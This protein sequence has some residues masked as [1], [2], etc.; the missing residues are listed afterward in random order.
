MKRTIFATGAGLAVVGMLT[1][2]A[3][4]AEASELAEDQRPADATTEVVER[5]ELSDRRVDG[6]RFGCRA[7]ATDTGVVVGCRWRPTRAEDAVSYQVWRIL[8]RGER[9]LVHRGGLDVTSFVDEELGHASF[10]RYAVL[11]LN[12]NKEIVGRSRV[13]EVRLTK[14]D[15]DETD[16]PVAR[17]R[18]RAARTGTA[19]TAAN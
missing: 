10:A 18:D 11:A 12:A 9:K 3:L 5:P 19:L 14:P 17:E 15:R 8:D 13:A 2:P 6:I 1:V 7:R 16:R 4:T